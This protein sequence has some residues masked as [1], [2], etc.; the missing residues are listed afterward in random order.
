MKNNDFGYV[1]RDLRETGNI[2][3]RGLAKETGFD[4][5]YLSRV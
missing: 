1:L 3:L 2:S 5:A 4:S